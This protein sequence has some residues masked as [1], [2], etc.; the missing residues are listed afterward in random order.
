MMRLYTVLCGPILRRIE[1][2]KVCIWLATSIQPEALD[3]A[4]FPLKKQAGSKDWEYG[5]VLPTNTV[6]NVHQMGGR[7]FVILL[8]VTP[9]EGR[10]KPLTP[11]G[12]DLLFK[13]RKED[14]VILNDKHFASRDG[15]PKEFAFTKTFNGQGIYTYPTLPFPVFVIPEQDRVNARIFYG[16]CRKTHGPGSDALNAADKLLERDWAAYRASPT[17]RL[18][19]FSLFLLGDQI[20]AD[21]LIEEVFG[22]VR[23]LADLLMG[24]E[25]EI[26][27][28]ANIAEISHKDLTTFLRRYLAGDPGYD[29]K[30]LNLPAK[31]DYLESYVPNYKR[32]NINKFLCGYFRR[33]KINFEDMNYYLDS[34]APDIIERLQFMANPK[35]LPL[36]DVNE[37]LPREYLRS[38]LKV[39]T[40]KV[41]NIGYKARRDFL[42]RNSAIS[43]VDD[44]H[45][46][47]FGE[48]AAL[49]LLN[50]GQFP[51]LEEGSA[52]W[53]KLLH[54]G[55]KFGTTYYDQHKPNLEGII[56]RNQRVVRLFANV[57]SYMIFDDHEITDEW[58]YDDVWRNAV[59]KRSV[60]GRRMLANGLA[61][62]WAFQAWGNDPRA[63]P[64]SLILPLKEFLLEPL[65]NQ[66]AR[67]PAKAKKYEDAILAFQDWA[68]IAPTNPIAVFLDNRT[69]RG[70]T[71]EMD[72]YPELNENRRFKAVRLMSQV[73]FAKIE[74]Q[75]VSARYKPDTPIIFCAP[76]PIFGSKLFEQ[77]Q[78]H[79]VDGSFNTDT[80]VAG[81]KPRAPG[82]HD[83]DFESWS[84]NPR[85]KYEFLSFLDR[86]VQP[87]KVAILSGDVHY[88]FHAS[89]L[90]YSRDTGHYYDV[91]QLTSSALK[92]NTLGYL[93]KINQ[94]AYLSLYDTKDEKY[95]KIEET[96]PVPRMIT[97]TGQ[98]VPHFLVSGHLIPYSRMIDKDTWLIF[99]NNIGL[100]DVRLRNGAPTFSNYFLESSYYLAPLSFSIQLPPP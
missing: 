51:F 18:P 96:Y 93:N 98:P 56:E 91:E 57:P 73:A 100:L 44:G 28:F 90:V 33:G 34:N 42:R 15:G 14:K 79:M 46:L 82:R 85:G 17:T 25:E 8:E 6:Y 83:N 37:V 99:H 77:G 27:E 66:G 36:I 26:P 62:Y 35:K 2:T 20:Y 12:Y 50:W 21:D 88:G 94:L 22:A 74:Q 72:Y 53:L 60:T 41:K 9:F 65:V 58:N 30:D 67:D 63:F 54:L 39:Q 7:L 81:L 92:N 1:P 84:A 40:E 11:Y 3:V 87:S 19:D 43:T 70:T 75:L 59:E 49:Y 89:V 24:Y 31:V 86:V 71:E 32:I 80:L 16:S 76:T 55:Y 48:F 68:F 29:I 47:S 64:A 4:V 95:K 13:F 78:L 97:A 38:N 52:E 69:L 45:L 5:E 10:F 61:S 23:E